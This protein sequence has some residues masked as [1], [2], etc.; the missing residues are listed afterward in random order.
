MAPSAE[1]AAIAADAPGRRVPSLVVN[2]ALLGMALSVALI[3]AE[4]T[5]RFVAHFSYLAPPVSRT[6]DFY[7]GLLY[8]SS[9]VPGLYYE[10]R[11]GFDKEHPVHGRIRTNRFGMRDAEPLPI[12]SNVARIVCI[13]DSFTFGYGVSEADAFPGVLEA[14]L[15][16]RAGA[17]Q[18]VEVLNLGVG[19]YSTVD[20]AQVVRQKALA[21]N[22]KI[23][24][25]GYVLNDP[26]TEPIQSLH[27]H[28]AP[29]AWWRYSAVLRGFAWTKNQWDIHRWG[30][31]DYTAYLHAQQNPKWHAVEESFRAIGA[32][33]ASRG[34]RT[35]VA[36]FPLFPK[37]DWQTYRYESLHRRVDE[38]ARA[39]G[40]DALDLLPTYRR[41]T[42]PNE[43][44]LT[45]EDN[46][47]SVLGHRVA[48]E[49]ILEKIGDFP[50]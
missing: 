12:D 10:L 39:A 35:I 33:T 31:G 13:G 30:G 36:I 1:V 5:L 41:H 27:A 49:A 3:M 38:A 40:L 37:T 24:V 48:A 50:R 32:A 23:I 34:I 14:R 15:R 6:A 8:R 47:P 11:P 9:D 17:R 2:L 4:G 42:D 16:A 22:P 25:L 7:R 29:V 19:G 45:P 21:W 26:E 46:H 43:L 18:A 44:W 28:F 20:E